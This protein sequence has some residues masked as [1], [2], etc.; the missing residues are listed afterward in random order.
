MSGGAFDYNQYKIGEIADQIEEQIRTHSAGPKDEWYF[1]MKP[2]T[3][4]ALGAAV[5]ALR[6]AEV[7][8]HRADWFFSGD[9]GEESFHE[10]LKE[11]LAK[12]DA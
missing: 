5:R 8:A 9:D 6:I 4:V 3:I 1:N 7:Y 10:R 12:L 11:D 2:E